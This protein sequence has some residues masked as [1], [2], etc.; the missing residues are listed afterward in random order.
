MCMQVDHVIA[1]CE[2]LALTAVRSSIMFKDLVTTVIAIQDSD[3][4][5][6]SHFRT[7]PLNP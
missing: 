6:T 4:S 1:Q 7:Q 2:C 5:R 3:S